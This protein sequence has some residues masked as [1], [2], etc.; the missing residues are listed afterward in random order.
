MARKR[1]GADKVVEI[2]LSRRVGWLL[3]SFLLS[4]LPVGQKVSRLQVPLLY[5]VCTEWRWGGKGRKERTQEQ[6]DL[7]SRLV[8]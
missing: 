6:A 7:R 5:T 2:S 1:F 8:S 4:Q 3:R